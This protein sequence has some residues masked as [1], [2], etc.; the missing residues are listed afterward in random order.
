MLRPTPTRI[1]LKEEDLKELEDSKRAKAA[2]AAP[3]AV[4]Y[5]AAVT[6]PVVRT[7]AERIGI[8]AAH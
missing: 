6:P 3:I 7:A 5:S 1:P 2:S 4:V 8:P